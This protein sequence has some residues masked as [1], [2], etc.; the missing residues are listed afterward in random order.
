[1]GNEPNF[2]STTISQKRWGA[3]RNHEIRRHG[4]LGGLDPKLEG[5]LNV[6]ERLV[7]GLSIR[8]NIVF[9]HRSHEPFGFLMDAD[10]E[11]SGHVDFH[12]SGFDGSGFF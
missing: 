8:G 2:G 3:P 10:G 12:K 4:K 5:F 6:A 9:R 11:R 7:F 1:M